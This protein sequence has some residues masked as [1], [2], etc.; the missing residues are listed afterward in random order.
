MCWRPEGLVENRRPVCLGRADVADKLPTVRK[1]SFENFLFLRG[2][3]SPIL[4]TTSS[5]GCSADSFLGP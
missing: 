1:W 2:N 3:L 4:K 5:I